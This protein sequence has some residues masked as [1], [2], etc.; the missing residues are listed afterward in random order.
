MLV[1]RAKQGSRN[2][3]TGLPEVLK[4]ATD[5]LRFSFLGAERESDDPLDGHPL[6]VPS[7]TD[8]CHDPECCFDAP[9]RLPAGMRA[10]LLCEAIVS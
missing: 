6:V 9:A 5:G 10:C 8:L 7:A 4:C 3:R 2:P 1:G